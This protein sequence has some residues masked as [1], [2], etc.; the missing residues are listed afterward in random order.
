[1]SN[2]HHAIVLAGIPQTNLS[3]FH[4]IRFSVGDPTAF[5]Q[6]PT[7]KRILILRDI[8]IARAKQSAHADEFYCNA[9]FTP[10][11]GLSGDREIA[12]AQ[13]LAEC[14]KGNDITS[15]TSDRS[16]PLVYAHMI[17]HAG[18]TL[19]CDLDLGVMERRAKDASELAHLRNAQAITEEVMRYACELIFNTAADSQGQLI[20]EGTPLTSERMI[21]LIDI[22]FLQRGASTPHGSIVA[23]GPIGADCHHRGAGVLRT[24][25]PII[26]DIFPHIRATGYHGDC[27]RTICHGDIPDQLA[28]MHAAVFEAKAAAEAAT[29]PGTTGEDVHKAAIGVIQAHGYSLG[30]AKDTDPD[31]YTTM[32]HGTGHGIGLDVHEP[33]L[34]DFNGPELIVGDVITIEP[35]L[36]S[37]SI[38]GLRIED[39]VAVTEDGYEN[40]NTLPTGLHW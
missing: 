26:I 32:A 39:M 34:L 8:E 29:K 6:L 21:S 19:D 7:G 36:Y 31:S 17:E 33:P 11:N 3:L 5:I 14:L 9:D 24:S 27:T 18:I 25:E 13:A 2:E 37:K 4:R 38:G 30:I 35:G 28:K 1:M 20:H 40:F 22:A 10:E 12:T 23:G 15:V 16:L